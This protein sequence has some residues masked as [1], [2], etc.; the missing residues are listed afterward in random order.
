MIQWF[1][2]KR[3]VLIFCNMT[4]KLRLMVKTITSINFLFKQKRYSF[5]FS[6]ISSFIFVT[7]TVAQLM[8]APQITIVSPSQD[9]TISEQTYISIEG[10]VEDRK[11]LKSID[12]S[13]N[14]LP[15]ESYRKRGIVI[16]EKVSS[17]MKDLGGI[18]I[19]PLKLKIPIQSIKSGENIIDIR[20]T[21][22]K[23][24]AAHFERTFIYTPP[25]ANLYAVV[26]AVN[27]YNDKNISELKYAENDGEG[28]VK[29]LKERLG[30]KKENLYILFGHDA[31]VDNI[32]RT[33][34][35]ELRKKAQKDDQILIYF[36]G[37]GAPE[38]E[39]KSLNADGIEKYLLAY[40]TELDALYAT[41][42]P[43][44]EIEYLFERY[45]SER[46]VFILDACFSGRVGRSMK[47]SGLAMRSGTIM[48]D[49]YNRMAAGKGK[50]I[51]AASGAN[52][53]SQELDRYK[54]GVF[55]YYLL[56][57]LDGKADYDKD[58]V[59]TVIEAHQ[60]V[61]KKVASETANTQ[62][63]E[64][65]HG[66][67]TNVVLGRAKTQS[68]NIDLPI[69]SGN[70]GRVIIEVYPEDAMI[71]IDGKDRGNGPVL[72]IVLAPGKHLISVSKKNYTIQEREFV[73]TQA[74]TAQLQ[75]TLSL[76]QGGPPP[77]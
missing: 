42:I 20:S 65:F 75:F 51:M 23:D 3:N 47:T 68:F 14:G 58:G 7:L 71:S 60:Y 73:A 62:K 6:I 49:F 8:A 30:I 41:A 61:E 31:T 53:G 2:T 46:V 72:N 9:E 67:L 76:S 12:I 13:L 33:I 39:S 66:N 36:A 57:A 77:P 15:L 21:N 38:P 27:K 63:P 35:V 56:E 24:E 1:P 16:L 10:Q 69:E 74:S 4:H 5:L 43:M 40:N 34:G 59:V 70:K 48:S 50:I 54:H 19:L 55:T 25:K 26:I 17:Q 52:E 22:L 18:D 45:A 37:H 44:R 28:I 29:Y 11:G 64:I 32:K